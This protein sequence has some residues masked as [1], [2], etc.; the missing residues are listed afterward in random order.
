[1]SNAAITDGD[2]VVVRE[3]EDAEN[4]DIVAAM[5]DG[6]ATVKTFRRPTARCG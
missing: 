3:Q 5:I 1:M 6:E 2:L 4:G